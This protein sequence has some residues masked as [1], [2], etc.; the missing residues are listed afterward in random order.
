MLIRKLLDFVDM[1][2]DANTV[3]V[4]GNGLAHDVHEQ[5]LNYFEEARLTPWK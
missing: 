2:A 5:F 3:F 1:G 4:P